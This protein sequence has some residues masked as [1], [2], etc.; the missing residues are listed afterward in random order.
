MPIKKCRKNNRPGYKWGDA[1][2]CYTYTYGD[3]QSET[4]AKRQAARQ[5]RAV[6]ASQNAKN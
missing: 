1:G 4:R 5:G 2:K 6:E 3:K